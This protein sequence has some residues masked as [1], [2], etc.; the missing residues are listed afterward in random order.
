MSQLLVSVIIPN[1]NYGRY[2]S[3]A[4]DSVLEQTYSNIE[5]IVVDDGSTDNSIEILAKYEI[6][7]VKV[8]QQTNRGV[9]AARNTGA[10]ESK[11]EYIAFLDADDIWNHTKIEKQLKVFTGDIGLVTCGMREFESS[12]NKTLAYLMSNKTNWNALDTLFFNYPVVSGSAIL[13]RRSTYDAV[14]GFDE[15][16][17]M[18]PSE[19]WEFF[20][21]VVENAKVVSLPEVLVSYRNHGRNGHLNI[22]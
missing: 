9:G 17:E 13:V 21:R 18:H 19:D 4:I 20:Y 8:I 1:Y 2:L 16:K 22:P 6:K 14:G 7:G 15:R 10:T 11:G 12:S 3:E 5:I